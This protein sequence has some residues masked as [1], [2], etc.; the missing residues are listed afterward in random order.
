[1]WIFFGLLA[2]S[3]VWTFVIAPASVHLLRFVPSDDKPLLKQVILFSAVDGQMLNHGKPAAGLKIERVY[4]WNAEDDQPK[5]GDLV[6]HKDVVLTDKEGRFHF[7]EVKGDP[8][9][10]HDQARMVNIINQQLY[11]LKNKSDAMLYFND[12]HGYEVGEETGYPTIQ[13]RCDIAT[14]RPIEDTGKR[15]TVIHCIG[16]SLGGALANLN[17]ALLQMRG[18][19]VAL[20]TLGSPR[21]GYLSFA[22]D[23]TKCI[24]ETQ[25]RRI[26]NPADPVAMVPLFPFVHASRSQSELYVPVAHS[27]MIRVANHLLG[28]GYKPV[29]SMSSWSQLKTAAQYDFDRSLM[30][31]YLQAYGSKSSMSVLAMLTLEQKLLDLG[32][33]AELAPFAVA[34]SFLSTYMTAFDRLNSFLPKVPYLQG[35]PLQAYNEVIHSLSQFL[36]RAKPSPNQ[37]RP[38]VALLRGLLGHF[39]TEVGGMASL[40]IRKA[41]AG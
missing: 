13:I 12:R 15:P 6:L 29:A 8:Q 28:D 30:K 10:E 4:S 26:M 1:M 33:A 34:Q 7:D 3:L 38:D 5:P 27:G 31:K 11:W 16:H 36:G 14:E 21:V 39:N 41:S 2:F 24:P 37:S 35:K 40:A 20:Y 25:I 18:Y 22:H 9:V 17:A 32:D 19:N 23:M